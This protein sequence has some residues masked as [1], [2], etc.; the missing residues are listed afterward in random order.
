MGQVHSLR[1][2]GAGLT[3]TFDCGRH[4][5]RL[6]ERLVA[7]VL[8]EAGLIQEFLAA[9]RRAQVFLDIGAHVGWYA[10]LAAKVNARLRVL[11][12]EPQIECLQEAVSN[13]K[14]NGARNLRWRCAVAGSRAGKSRPVPSP[15]D[16]LA[17][18]FSKDGHSF[19]GARRAR[20]TTH[21]L[22]RVD[23]WIQDIQFEPDLV[24]IDVEGAE[25]DVLKGMSR[26][27]ARR[28]PVL[29]LELHPQ[30][31]PVVGEN[32]NQVIGTLLV[33]LGYRIDRWDKA[34]GFQGIVQNGAIPRDAD[35]VVCRPNSVLASRW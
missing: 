8:H 25:L 17:R 15:A 4:S 20:G 3:V 14:S 31:E 5:G 12:I 7:G 35:F 22:I 26:L 28:R 13:A 33:K 24:K 9:A 18:R 23:Q 10:S 27:L 2:I 32:V 21:H 34:H 1:L 30:L 6:G 11:L 16:S 19:R 29:F